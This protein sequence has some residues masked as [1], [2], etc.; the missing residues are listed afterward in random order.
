MRFH[1]PTST[2]SLA[3][4]DVPAVFR[5]HAERMVYVHFKDPG[6]TGALLS[7][8]TGI[9]DFPATRWATL[10]EADF[11]GWIV[12]DLTGTRRIRQLMSDEHGLP[13]GAGCAVRIIRQ[14]AAI[15]RG[16]ATG[17]FGHSAP[18][19]SGVRAPTP[20]AENAGAQRAAQRSDEVGSRLRT[21]NAVFSSVH[22]KRLS[23]QRLTL[24]HPALQRRGNYGCAEV[25]RE[26]SEHDASVPEDA[27][28]SRTVAS[29]VLRCR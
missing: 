14:R 18:L 9:V 21:G 26:G 22:S 1:C 12:V 24:L 8:G 13:A 16:V 23:P 17:R 28:T 29:A 7:C 6:P 20:G 25:V 15:V 5:H 19:R 11:S 10:R 2:R 27:L 3:D 4:F